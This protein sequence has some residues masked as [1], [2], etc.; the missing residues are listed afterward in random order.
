[1]Y[2]YSLA[3]GGLLLWTAMVLVPIV[4]HLMK[5]RPS[6]PTRFPSFA[7]LRATMARHGSRNRLRK[8]L[9]LLSRCAVIALT[10]LAFAWPYIP[11]LSPGLKSATVILWD[12]SYSMQAEPWRESLIARAESSIMMAGMDAP[13]QLGMAGLDGVKW[14]GAFSG[15]SGELLKWFREHCHKPFNST[16]RNALYEAEARLMTINAPRKRIVI[17]SDNQAL[18]WDKFDFNRILSPGIT[19]GLELPPRLERLRNVA[20]NKVDASVA[21]RNGESVIQLR[22][23][24]ENHGN[25]SVRAHVTA[26][27]VNGKECAGLTQLPACGMAVMELELPL[28]GGALDGGAGLGGY[29]ELSAGDDLRADNRRYFNIPGHCREKV[30]ITSPRAGCPDFVGMAFADGGF[31][32]S[33]DPD[34]CVLAVVQNPRGLDKGLMERIKAELDKGC[35]AALFCG[36]SADERECLRHFGIELSGRCGTMRRLDM[37]D[38][39]HPVFSAYRNSR[40]GAWFGGL[41]FDSVN[42]KL[43]PETR[44][45]AAF[46]DGSPAIVEKISGKGR[47]LVFAFLLGGRHGN[48]H[49]SSTFLPF[50]RELFAYASALRRESSRVGDQECSP[51]L[52]ALP[53]GAVIRKQG[54]DVPERLPFIP[55]TPG[56]YVVENGAETYMFSVNVPVSESAWSLVPKDFSAKLSAICP[57]GGSDPLPVNIS[58]AERMAALSHSH[59]PVWRYLLAAALILMLLELP[60]SNRTAL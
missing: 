25:E 16:M 27:V 2:G 3:F 39:E 46:G 35:V 14:S 40:V 9:V 48:W 11:S 33:D 37:L 18:P 56:N 52:V 24:L 22:V 58:G 32:L 6:E 15:R 17:V 36:D 19:V 1:M 20:V 30:L 44:V 43:S 12:H 13:V 50:W 21:R 41:F 42:L 23:E 53:S 5:N 45:L 38:L 51:S 28:P 49:A 31:S 10:A 60:L 8:W 29:V 57:N 26:C 34:G 4:L 54:S 7:F 55:D 47:L 59:D